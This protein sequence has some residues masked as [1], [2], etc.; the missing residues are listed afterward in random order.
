MGGQSLVDLLL[1]ARGM[2]LMIFASIPAWFLFFSAGFKRDETLGYP[3]AL[4]LFFL[5]HTCISN[6][7]LQTDKSNIT[8]L[9]YSVMCILT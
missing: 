1:D 5:V 9:T 3:S 6:S 7:N 4:C 8:Q 2:T